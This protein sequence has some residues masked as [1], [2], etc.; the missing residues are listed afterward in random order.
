MAAI[1]WIRLNRIKWTSLP[2]VIKIFSQLLA[3]HFDGLDETIWIANELPLLSSIQHMTMVRG[4]KT[5]RLV[6]WFS[7]LVVAG[8]TKE[9]CNNHSFFKS[10]SRYITLTKILQAYLCNVHHLGYSLLDP[11]HTTR[12]IHG[13]NKST[14]LFPYN[15]PP[16]LNPST[17]RPNNDYKRTST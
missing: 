11:F 1:I 4:L 16:L 9:W 5:Y 12:E 14:D 10:A 17:P 13:L 7:G 6:Y 3:W 2:N 15:Y 8:F